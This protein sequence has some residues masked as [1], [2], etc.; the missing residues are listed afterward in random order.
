[1]LAEA[2]TLVA[3]LV[4]GLAFDPPLTVSEW[5]QE[6]R[7]LS[8][9]ASS[10]PGRWRNERTPYLTEIMDALGRGSPVEEV[11][12]MKGAQVGGTEAGN[13]W[14]A[15]IIDVSPGPVL[16]VQP[17]VDIARRFSRQRLE[18]LI[19]DS[20][21]LRGRVSER[22]SRDSQNTVLGKDFPGG[23]LMLAG[24]NSAAGLRSMPVRDLFLD[25]VDAYPLDVD[26]EGD[27]ISLAKARTRNFHNRK[28]L[29]VSTPTISGQS[30]IEDAFEASDQRYYHVPCPECGHYAPIEWKR[31]R[32]EKGDPASVRLACEGCGALISETS[33]SA[34]L[35]AGRWVP[36]FPERAVR[37]YHLSALYSP[38]GWFSWEDAVKAWEEAQSNEKKLR[39][40]VNT[41]LGETWREKGEAPEWQR[42]YHRR[43]EY[44]IGTVPAGGVFLT[45]GCDVQKDRLEVEVVA[46]AERMESW[47]ID[48]VVI[49]GDPASDVPWRALEE[50]LNRPYPTET[51]GA[52]AI[53][54]LAVD[55]GYETQAVYDWCRSQP[56][57]RVMAC[58]GNESLRQCVGPVSVVDVNWKGKRLSR[59]AR[60][61]PIGSSHMKSELYGWLRQPQPTSPTAPLPFG[62]CHFP[63]YAEHWFEMLTAEELRVRKVRGYARPLWEKIRERNEALDCRVLARAAAASLGVDRWD[64]KRWRRERITSAVSVTASEQPKP[65]ARRRRERSGGFDGYQLE[66]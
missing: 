51:G 43:E 12:F 19:E 1:M 56:F 39:V 7:F 41:I 38:Y 21:R 29:E 14:L 11:V 17:T 60:V 26:G 44:R 34:M 6:H 59:G 18:P 27:P 42:L 8:P 31:L 32:W 40:F 52:I 20:P 65:K 49:P 25:E 16:A 58:K 61:W 28:V 63:Q 2:G 22:R 33:K 45:A 54:K 23:V 3:A 4:A 57:A 53:A 10:E 13:N 47:S 62:W 48:Y 24:A 37:G 50:L 46:W 36:T 15:Y 30:R 64:E 35:A 9:K 55:S 5:A 66:L